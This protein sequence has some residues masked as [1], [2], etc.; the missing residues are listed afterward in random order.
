MQKKKILT[1]YGNQ[2]VYKWNP[3]TG[4][5]DPCWFCKG[6]VI[7]RENQTDKSWKRTAFCSEEC[8]KHRSHTSSTK[9]IIEKNTNL[10]DWP[11][12]IHFSSFEPGDNL[13]TRYDYSSNHISIG[14]S[15][16]LCADDMDAGK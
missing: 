14:T 2:N 1:H 4:E 15:A 5:H 13:I 3:L 11:S 7:K 16:R 8:R 9:R 6:P 12:N 10:V